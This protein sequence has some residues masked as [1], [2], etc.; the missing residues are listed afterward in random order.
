MESVG[1]W[2]HY[3]L[4]R[5]HPEAR[6]RTKNNY[7]RAFVLSMFDVVTVVF[8]FA[9][10]AWR[11]F[12]VYFSHEDADI[13]RLPTVTFLILGFVVWAL[14]IL[15]R[16]HMRRM[17]TRQTQRD[18]RKDQDGAAERI[19]GKID[20]AATVA[21]MRH[22]QYSD[23]HMEMLKKILELVEEREGSGPG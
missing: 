1:A 2:R 9:A 8:F 15:Y 21:T 7:K 23:E 18:L 13:V 14:R 10:A 5:D 6:T 22:G 12:V 19:E 20:S 16:G 11:T 3:T 17:E 4:V